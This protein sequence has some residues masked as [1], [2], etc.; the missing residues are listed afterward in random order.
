MNTTRSYPR[1][2]ALLL[3]A[4][5]PLWIAS[6]GDEC[7]R[8]FDFF[9]SAF[10]E[11][12]I[13]SE[14]FNACRTCFYS[15]KAV[16]LETPAA[17]DRNFIMTMEVTSPE[18]IEPSNAQVEV[19][20]QCGSGVGGEQRF[21]VPLQSDGLF[22][23]TGR[24]E[25]DGRNHCVGST[26]QRTPALWSVVVARITEEPQSVEFRWEVEYIEYNAVTGAK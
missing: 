24:F 1:R 16:A 26:G 8:L 7:P 6:T 13:Y 4:S 18:P 17:P 23:L 3:L 20:L 2:K 5:T 21:S 19:V 14:Y 12:T 11:R 22:G 25:R 9:P 15:S 10:E